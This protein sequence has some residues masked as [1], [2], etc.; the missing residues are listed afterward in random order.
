MVRKTNFS[1]FKKDICMVLLNFNQFL[2]FIECKRSCCFYRIS[3]DIVTR[4][5]TR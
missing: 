3:S 2:K 1:D 5:G 4:L